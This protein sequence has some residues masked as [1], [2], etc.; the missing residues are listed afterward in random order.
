TGRGVSMDEAREWAARLLGRP[1]AF[2]AGAIVAPFRF[3]SGGTGI[4]A[5][6]LV[7]GA[8]PGP[9]DS[10][11]LAAYARHAAALLDGE[12][13]RQHAE[14]NHAHTKGLLE[15]AQR[16]AAV[17]SPS[18]VSRHV[19]DA[20]CAMTG[21]VTGS[22]WGW[23]PHHRTL[24]LAAERGRPIGRTRFTDDDVE[25][26]DGLETSRTQIVLDIEDVASEALRSAMRR[27]RADRV[28]IVPV[29]AGSLLGVI[30]LGFEGHPSIDDPLA[31]VLHGIADLAATALRNGL[32]MD[33]MRHQALHDTLTGLPNRP[34]IED[35]VHQ[36]IRRAE[37]TRSGLA[38][39]FIDLDRFK[40]V[41]DTLGHSAGDALIRKVA[42]R[43]SEAVRTE[44][45]VARMGGDEF[46]LLLPAAGEA[47][48]ARV[49]EKVI[50]AMRQPFDLDG[51]T[52]YISCSVGIALWP[53]HGGDYEE[54]LVHADAAMYEAKARGRNTYAFHAGPTTRRRELLD[55]ENRL[56]TAI[57]RGE[58]TVL[59]QP[60]VELL[61]GSVRGIEALVR[62]DHPDLG[63]LT[64]DRFLHLAEESGV[65]SRIDAWV[66]TSVL[67][68]ARGW[69][70]AG[71]SLRVAM[72]LSTSDLR[73]RSLVGEIASAVTD[74]RVPFDLVELE[75]TDRVALG[76]EDLRPALDD[77]A[78]LGVRLAVDDFGVGS[79]VLGR[80]QHGP[81]DTLKIDRSLV[82]DI[83]VDRR[84]AAIV[85]ALVT[86][87]RELGLEV[88][89]EG[90]ETEVQ[91]AKL[92]TLGCSLGQGFWLGA[93]VPAAEIAALAR[94]PPT[95][96]RP[97]R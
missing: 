53:T 14:R 39:M 62:W 1:A 85:H 57:D 25:G 59:Y 76:E 4:L 23:D 19:V 87:A 66:R 42:T 34:L 20:V 15:L 54:L 64:P 86:M 88:V 10:R 31:S 33:T 82:A 71:L 37:R 21:C 89:A 11:L 67:T 68:A 92:T 75:V 83:G 73:R 72:N 90:V 5:A 12:V 95:D 27:T 70:D 32:L 35:R 40:N 22:V 3:G 65:I 47:A 79:S 46:V 18:E 9:I 51:R 58:L 61:T 63:R 50:A 38:L 6:V 43:L 44:D 49:A 55:L 24:R 80:L 7:P 96:A 48:A 78:A 41:N 94:R 56:H 17:Q 2:V 69:L 84:Q 91:A 26:L 36:A 45:T 74:A 28:L 93:P 77:L 13:S 81:F 8:G 97:G 29:A 60:Q 30:A 16:L 52:L